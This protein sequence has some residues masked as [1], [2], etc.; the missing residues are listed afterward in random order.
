[1][2][3]VKRPRVDPTCFVHRTAQ[4]I[5]D[6]TLGARVSVWP[7]ASIRGDVE[8]IELGEGSNVQDNCV[9]H[10]DKG[11]PVRI[12]TYVTMGHMSIV[13]GATVEDDCL[14]G[15]RAVVLNGARV[16]KGSLVAAGAVVT[17]GMEIPALSLVMGLPAKVVKTD[18]NLV[19]SNRANA[20]R[21]LAYAD[22]HRRGTF[23]VHSP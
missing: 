13:H 8:P 2:Q 20:E 19:A 12:G 5:G 6:V 22:L 18:P 11:F 3:A 7:F 23:G 15:I 4:I 17:P 21:Y 1:M 14:I 9:I 16:G 10:T